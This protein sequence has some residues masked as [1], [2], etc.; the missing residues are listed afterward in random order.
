MDL[1][2]DVHTFRHA[3]AAPAEDPLWRHRLH[4]RVHELRYGFGLHRRLTEGPAGLYAEVLGSAPRLTH[5]IALLTREHLA[6]HA[7]LLAF[8]RRVARPEA[9]V[10]E[11]RERGDELCD[12]LTQHRRRGAELLHQAYQI[13]L[14]G[15]T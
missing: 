5:A 8:Q 6:V 2:R 9:A 13:D 14:G 12:G 4:S 11:L 3:L 7:A 10:D 15:E 1:S